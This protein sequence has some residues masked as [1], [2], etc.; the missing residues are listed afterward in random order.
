MHQDLWSVAELFDGRLLV[1]PDYQRGYAWDELQ[2]RD[3]LEDLEV[4]D[5]RQVHYTGTVVLHRQDARYMDMEGRSLEVHHVVDGQQR[6]T[7]VALLMGAIRHELASF[8]GNEALCEGIRKSFLWVEK[9]R[10]GERLP[11]LRLQAD[12]GRY[13]ERALGLA[14]A[15]DGPRTVAERRVDYART[16][17][18]S[19]LA[20]QREKLAG[21]YEEWLIALYEKVSRQLKTTLF[22]VEREG[23]VGVIFEVMNN[24]GKPLSE[25]EKVKNYLLYI[26]GKLEDDGSLA[27]KI[28][29]TWAHI[30]ENLMA[31]DL[32][33]S[34]DENQLLRTHWLLAY[35]ADERKW[36]G[37]R[38]VKE[39]FDLRTH[40][41]EDGRR[42]LF[43]DITHYLDT[44]ESVV[45][46]FRD[47]EKPQRDQALTRLIPDE[48]LRRDARQTSERLHRIGVVAP[49]R[50]IVCAARVR[51]AEEP[52]SYVRI[53]HACE[54]FS[55]LVYR[56]AGCRSNAGRSSLYHLAHR[57]YAGDITPEAAAEGIAKR[58]GWY[59][60][61]AAYE[62]FF[63]LDEEAPRNFYHWGGLRYLLYE[64]ETELAGARQ[65]NL[66]WRELHARQPK[67]TVE[68]VLP[69]TPTDTYWTERFDED[70]IS[71]WTH[72]LGNLCLTE[73]NSSYGNKPFPQKRGKAG[74]STRCYATS[75]LFSE[76]KL[77]EATGGDP[78]A[79]TKRREELVA[80]AKKRW[81]WTGS[82]VSDDDERAAVAEAEAK[83][84]DVWGQ[85]NSDQR[86]V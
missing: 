47:L 50:P 34:S 4:L 78:E 8:D 6:L 39:R 41:D 24:R 49:F 13:F 64:W 46:A 86:G 2:L 3:F 40:R 14:E 71:L 57:L 82:E 16:R 72:D 60:S 28:N 42:R 63:V 80:W 81:P 10:T 59:L 30:L 48:T 83:V 21:R 77:A 75:N 67:T 27:R 54:R 36:D 37:S 38:T 56:V 5:S 44:L 33:R 51:C 29:T 55:F 68:H 19:Y 22:P 1:V 65:V 25:L 84:E 31:A 35:N 15:A 85:L 32:V 79:V 17:F 12:L 74:S 73:D 43:Q 7:T 52:A 18:R 45:V 70:A 76:R 23:D 9:H 62:S 20:E 69:Q 53:L 26:G 61:E 58:V 66:S 11:K